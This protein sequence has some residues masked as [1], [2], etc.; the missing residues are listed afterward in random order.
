MGQLDATC[1]APTLV[2]AEVQHL[3]AQVPHLG[4][5]REVVVLVVA[6]QVAFGKANFETR[7]SLDR[8]K[9]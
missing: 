5:A 9:G 1:T 4:R 3:Q 6:A 8:F 2:L 7:N